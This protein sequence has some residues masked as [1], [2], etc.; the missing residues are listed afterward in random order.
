MFGPTEISEESKLIFK[1]YNYLPPSPVDLIA[2]SNLTG[3]KTSKLAEIVGMPR[4]TISGL[5]GDKATTKG[6]SLEYPAWRMW[7]EYTNIVEPFRYVPEGPLNPATLNRGDDFSPP[8]PIELRGLIYYF[9]P[10][11]LEEFYNKAGV[12]NEAVKRVL[13]GDWVDFSNPLEISKD[14]WFELLGNLGI[15]SIDD[16]KKPP[17]LRKECL[18]IYHTKAHEDYKETGVITDN[19]FLPP[20]VGEVRAVVAWMSWKAKVEV[21]ASLIGVPDITLI[22]RMQEHEGKPMYLK[23][24]EWRYLLEITGIVEKV[25]IPVLTANDC[26][27]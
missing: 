10:K 27:S 15:N 11:E 23:Y 19:L 5:M 25:D 24:C 26:F 20:T 1:N 2:I 22:S 7:L 14:D 17:Q 9:N 6:Y 3:L 4:K 16:L 8:F 13:F 21:K 18:R 12:N